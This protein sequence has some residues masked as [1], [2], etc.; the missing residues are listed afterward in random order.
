MKVL[1]KVVVVTGGGSGIGKALCQRFHREGAKAIVVADINEAAAKAVAAT[2]GGV[3]V[4]CDVSDEQQVLSLV[5]NTEQTYGSLDLFCSNAGIGFGDGGRAATGASNEQWQLSWGVNVMAHVYAARAAIPGMVERGGGYLLQTC[6][7]AGL[8]SQI[9]DAAYSTTKH[10]AVG[11]AESLAISHGD[12]GVKV[13]VLCPQYVAT[14]MIGIAEGE[15]FSDKDGVISPDQLADIVVQGL[16]QEQFLILTH[17]EV[18]NYRQSK[19]ANYDRWLGG[20]RKLRRL[21]FG[22]K[23]DMDIGDLTGVNK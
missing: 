19:A 14:P 3:G 8:L 10:A 4:A 13:S 1:G 2:V 11:L 17:P 21:L 18:E 5:K 6:S 12:E 16:D 9:G 23:Q 22:D 15:D 20:M 7:A